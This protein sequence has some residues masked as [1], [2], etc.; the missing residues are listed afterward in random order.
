[1]DLQAGTIWDDL[2]IILPNIKGDIVDAGCGLQPFRH[3]FPRD[4][5]YV[6]LDSVDSKTHFGY[7]APDTLYYSGNVWPLADQ[8][9]DF[10]L[11][12]ET[13]E[14]VPEPS[15]FLNEAFRVLRPGGTLLLTIPFSARWHFIPYDYWRFT[16]SGLDQMLKKSGFQPVQVLSRGNSL[17]V[18]CYKIMAFCFSL[19]APGETPV[20]SRWWSRLLGILCLPALLLAALV[21]NLSRGKSG[22][23]DCLGYTVLAERPGPL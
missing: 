2:S 11:C 17:T 8:S 16:P 19:L 12:T 14:H 5:R 1:M 13:L 6:G 9:Y 21:G 7:E 3:M 23:A 10:I 20:N 4:I 22:F 15:L 18:A